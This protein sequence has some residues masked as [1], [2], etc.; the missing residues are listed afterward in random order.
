MGLRDSGKMIHNANRTSDNRAILEAT[1][2]PLGGRRSSA[3]ESGGVGSGA[4]H[5]VNRIDQRLVR[6]LTVLGFGLPLVAYLWFVKELAVDVPIADQW[7]NVPVIKGSYIHFFDWGQMWAQHN[8]NRI[9]FPNIAVLL[10][11]H[12]DH[13]DIRFELT[14]RTCE[15]GFA[16]PTQR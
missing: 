13:F 12:A 10:L 5:W 15:D 4:T 11:A 2:V 16:S 1:S 3:D 9:F 8:E 14:F 7:V 6:F